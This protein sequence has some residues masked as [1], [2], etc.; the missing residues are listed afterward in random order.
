MA[1]HPAVRDKLYSTEMYAG[2][3]LLAQ[4]ERKELGE[5]DADRDGRMQ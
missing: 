5:N 2:S 3:G 1:T 4:A